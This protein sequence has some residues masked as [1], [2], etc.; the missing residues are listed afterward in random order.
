MVKKSDFNRKSLIIVGLNVVLA[1]ILV[2]AILW[3][4]RAWL[5][6]YTQHGVEIP[7]QDVRGLLATD[8]KLLLESQGL[9]M[10]VIDST[11]SSKVPLSTI[12]D[13]DPKPQSKAKEGRMVYVTIN[14]AHK[15]QVTMPNLQDMS[16]RQA[17]ITLRGMGLEVDSIYEYRP[18]AFRD[19]ILDITSNGVS[20]MPGEKVTVGTKVKLVVGFGRGD[21]QVEVPNVVGLTLQEARSLLLSHRL[22]IG[23]TYY[24]EPDKK[25]VERYIYDQ[26]PSEGEQLL[27][28]EPI[29]IYLST[30]KEKSTKHTTN[31]QEE[32]EWF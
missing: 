8:A 25:D 19:L 12:V 15:R 6:A 4:V 31:T 13:Q 27:E 7:V 1:I 14:A 28:G 16:Y 20:I 29:S 30:D 21:A 10:M 22:T 5:N 24:D 9:H 18:S 32:E 23:A 2:F 26:S 3:G 11:Y 17:E